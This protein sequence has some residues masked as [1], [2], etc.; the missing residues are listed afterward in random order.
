MKKTNLKNYKADQKTKYLKNRIPEQ[1]SLSL[2]KKFFYILPI[3]ILSVLLYAQTAKFDFAFDDMIIVRDNRFVQ[4]GLKGIPDILTKNYIAGYYPEIVGKAYRPVP[5]LTF[6][7]E[8]ELFGQNSHI[9][10]IDNLF[11]YVLGTIFLFL[12]LQ[13]LFRNKHPLFSLVVCLLYVAHPVH[14][15]VVANIKSRDEL[16]GFL[17]FFIS[18]WTLL[19]FLDKRKLKFLAYSIIFYFFSLASK[20]IYLTTLAVIPVALYFFRDL[21]KKQIALMT[22]PY[23]VMFLLFLIIRDHVIKGANSAVNIPLDKLDNCLLAANNISDRIGT[24]IFIMGKYL[25]TLILPYNLVSDYS[26]N[27]IPLVGISNKWVLITLIIY[28]V[29]FIYFYKKFK[30]KS[31][32]AFAILYFF[33]TISIVS[34]IFVLS[35]NAYAERFLFL[36]SLSVCLIIGLLLFGNYKSVDRSDHSFFKYQLVPFMILFLILGLYS[37]KT[38]KYSPV[39]KDNMTLFTYMSKKLPENAKARKI[40]GQTYFKLAH[41]I[42]NNPEYKKELTQKAIKELKA[43]LSIYERQNS[44]FTYLADCYIMLND[45]KSAEEALKKQ[46]TIEPQDNNA[47]SSLGV[48]YYRN[49]QIEEAAQIWESIDPRKRSSNDNYNLYLAYNRLGQ[50]DKANQYLKLSGK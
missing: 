34:S 14:V 38:I 17:N 45:L 39:W 36:P 10:H 46:L 22:L 16:L 48:V 5:L 18:F 3:A 47:K 21:S 25:K 28:I 27:S 49:G 7:L 42:S 20:E 2:K 41:S 11:L 6:A 50:K 15:D 30:S 33:I 13:L 4:Q 37:F 32:Y 1:Q 12:S 29:I 35:S 19:L 23:A 31:P 44:G 8:T 40:L 24:N 43:G 9:L 26:F